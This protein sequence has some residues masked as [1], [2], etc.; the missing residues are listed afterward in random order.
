[1]GRLAGPEELAGAAVER[2]DDAGLADGQ[3]RLARTSV[4]LDVGEH[5]LKDMIEIPVIARQELVI[6][7]DLAGIR[8]QRQRRIGIEDGAVAGAAHDLAMRDRPAGAPVDQIQGGIVAARA[9]DRAAVT[10]VRR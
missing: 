5:L 3:K 6:P 8:I 9:P 7:N 2:P 4:Y 1:M 10:L